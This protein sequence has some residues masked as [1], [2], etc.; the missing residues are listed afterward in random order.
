MNSSEDARQ[1]LYDPFPSVSR[2]APVGVPKLTGSP[3]LRLPTP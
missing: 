2:E 3:V 1:V